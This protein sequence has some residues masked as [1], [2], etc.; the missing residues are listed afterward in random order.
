V[1]NDPETVNLVLSLLRQYGWETGYKK[2]REAIESNADPNRQ[3]ALQFFAGWVAA[4]RGAYEEAERSFEECKQMPALAAWAAF[5]Q[6]FLAMRRHNYP[7][8]RALLDECGSLADG[9]GDNALRGAVEHLRGTVCF[10]ERGQGPIL[11][12]LRA[13]LPSWARIISAPAGCSTPLA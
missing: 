11:R 12:H 5:G 3:D 6:A 10:H 2:L 8:A 7:R 1:H 9:A 13:A 4:E